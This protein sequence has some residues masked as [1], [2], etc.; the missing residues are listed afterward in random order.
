MGIIRDDVGI[1]VMN[2]ICTNFFIMCEISSTTKRNKQTHM[3]AEL[4]KYVQL[5]SNQS[6]TQKEK[7]ATQTFA[8]SFFAFLF[9][10]L[11]QGPSKSWLLGV[12]HGHLNFG[13]DR[14][15]PIVAPLQG[16]ILSSL[17]SRE[18]LASIDTLPTW[19]HFKAS[20]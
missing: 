19:P 17:S 15:F 3:C 10:A 12:T 20:A 13:F 4:D 6:T 16:L 9:F 18:G 2:F 14:H 11:F 5:K 1:F 8:K 7:G